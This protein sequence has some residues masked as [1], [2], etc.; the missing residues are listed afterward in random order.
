[1]FH[2]HQDGDYQ[3]ILPGIRVKTLVYGEKTLLAEFH[4]QKGAH[5]THH[6]HAHEQ[7]GFLVSGTL[8]LTLEEKVYEVHPGDAWCVP[9]NLGHFAESLSESVMVQVFSPVREDYL[10]Y[11]KKQ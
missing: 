6:Q 4:M 11:Y 7:T 5:F 1:M 10:S 2:S 9:P 3:Q 8:R